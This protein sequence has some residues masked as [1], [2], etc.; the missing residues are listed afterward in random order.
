[1]VPFLSRHFENKML[2]KLNNHFSKVNRSEIT[3]KSL[4]EMQLKL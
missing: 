3:E 1:M 4:A 2:L